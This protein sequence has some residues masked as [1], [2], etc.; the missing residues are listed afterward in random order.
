MNENEKLVEKFFA[1]ICLEFPNFSPAVA[2][3]SLWRHWK[4]LK[5]PLNFQNTVKFLKKRI[6]EFFPKN[7]L[8]GHTLP[9]P[10]CR[11][12]LKGIVETLLL[13]LCKF[14]FS[15]SLCTYIKIYIRGRVQTTWTEF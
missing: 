1:R 7:W 8:V 12:S 3:F 2:I 13:I 10:R 15:K 6:P 4:S 14:L 9:S 11:M 5:K